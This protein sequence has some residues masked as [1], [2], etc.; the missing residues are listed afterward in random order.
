MSQQYLTLEL[1]QQER[2]RRA[3]VREQERQR[4][5]KLLRVVPGGKQ[6]PEESERGQHETN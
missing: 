5:K 4:V 1:I 6:K 2:A 3:R